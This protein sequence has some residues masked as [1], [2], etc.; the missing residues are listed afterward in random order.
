M[1][2]IDSIVIHCSA[3]R[4]GQNVTAK[5]IE[6]MH[7]QRGFKT[8]G[9]HWVVKL[10][11]SVERGRP[12]SMEGAHCN[13]SGFSKTAYNKHSVGICYIG[14]IDKE[15]KPKDTRTPA[16]KDA[17]HKLVAEICRRYKIKEIIGHRDTSPDKNNNDK[18]E[19]WEWIKSCPCFDVVPEF[20][21]YI[22]K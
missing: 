20:S 7:L 14:G 22:S 13:T 12:E 1:N 15:G 17:L 4:E 16:Q 10:D 19:S 2:N 3:T 8:I 11:G 6:K 9:Y 21:R 5:D 18:I